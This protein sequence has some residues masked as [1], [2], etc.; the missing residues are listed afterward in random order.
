MLK[1]VHLSALALASLAIILSSCAS[2]SSVA[3][4]V[5]DQ[6]QSTS[7]VSSMSSSQISFFS[8]ID[9][10]VME[11]FEVASPES[12]REGVAALKKPTGVDYSDAEK[13]LLYVARAIMQIAWKSES[14]SWDVPAI[15]KPNQYTGAVDSAQKGIYELSTDGSDFFASVLPTLA[16]LV[17]T[18]PDDATLE[19]AH[20]DLLKALGY[21]ADSVLANYLMGTLQ[22]K[23]GQSEQ[24]LQSF[25]TSSS[26]YSQGSKEISFQIAASCYLSENYELSLSFAESLLAESPHNLDVLKLCALSS[27]RLGDLESTENYV[28]R[29]LLVEPD[30]VEFVLL[31]AQ[32]LVERQDY[33]RASALLDACQKRGYTSKEYYQ[34]RVRL[35]RDW[36]RNSSKAVETAAEALSLYPDDPD[37]LLLAAQTSSALSSPVAGLSA[38]DIAQA[39]LVLDEDN[40]AALLILASE[41]HKAGDDTRAYEASSRLL[42][43]SDPANSPTKEAQAVHVDIC[44]ALGKTD[45]ALSLAQ[46]MWQESSSDESACESYIKALVASGRRAEAAQMIGDLLPTATASMKSF[47]YYQRSF[48]HT[49]QEDVLSDL[50]SSLT[51]NAR[52]TDSLFRLY[53][54]YYG[55][56]D[57]RRAQYYLKQIIALDPSNTS[58]LERNSELERLLSH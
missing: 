52:N 55:R 8:S 29:I 2:S 48:M 36:S 18:S 6:Q 30:A 3:P 21:K 51:A 56:R 57:W 5:S 49:A 14:V 54:I 11:L 26:R 20:G 46:A 42:S 47:L 35:L 53:Q 22:L 10:A 44:L 50:R 24:A 13:T 32:I 58:Y 23:L 41:L 39:V 25:T 45:E 9:P 28:L 31:R 19:R 34:L 7:L 4:P 12:L 16:L 27:Y 17:I 33:I 40:E 15:T 1:I 43:L 37:V 38:G